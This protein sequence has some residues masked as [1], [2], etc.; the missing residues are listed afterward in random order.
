MPS[1]ILVLV[2]SIKRR[3]R[4]NAI[5]VEKNRYIATCLNK[6]P[7]HTHTNIQMNSSDIDMCVRDVM[8]L[9]GSKQL[10]IAEKYSGKSNR[11]SLPLVQSISIYLFVDLS[12]DL[13]IN[14]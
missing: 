6:T 12:F 13:S 5:N 3:R 1:F 4:R 8:K 14:P 7:P 11:L 2:R 9:N 10:D